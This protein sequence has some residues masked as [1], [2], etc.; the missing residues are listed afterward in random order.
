MILYKI[1]QKF[2]EACLQKNSIA[3]PILPKD[4]QS[5][6][7]MASKGLELSAGQS[8]T[9][10]ETHFSQLISSDIHT[11]FDS[12]NYPHEL[13]EIACGLAAI[14][15]RIEGAIPPQLSRVTGY[16]D[17][18]RLRWTPDAHMFEYSAGYTRPECPTCLEMSNN[19]D[20]AAILILKH[21]TCDGGEVVLYEGDNSDHRE[22][23]RYARHPVHD[24]VIYFSTNLFY[25]VTS[26]TKGTLT[27]LFQTLSISADVPPKTEHYTYGSKSSGKSHWCGIQKTRALYHVARYSQHPPQHPFLVAVGLGD[28]VVVEKNCP[29]TI[30]KHYD[31][32]VEGPAIIHVHFGMSFIDGKVVP[33]CSSRDV[34][35]T[36]PKGHSSQVEIIA[37]ANGDLEAAIS[38][39][40]E[41]E[42]G[43]KD[44]KSVSESICEYRS[45]V[46]RSFLSRSNDRKYLLCLQL[47]IENA[48]ATFPRGNIVI[49]H[50]ERAHTLEKVKE[51]RKKSFLKWY[52]HKFKA[53]QPDHDHST[54]D[55]RGSCNSVQ[56]IPE[57]AEILSLDYGVRYHQLKGR[58]GAFSP[59]DQKVVDQ[60]R[61]FGY[62]Y[63][64]V[65]LKDGPVEVVPG[66][67]TVL[68]DIHVY[69]ND[70]DSDC[71]S[72]RMYE[73]DFET[74]AYF[75]AY[76]Q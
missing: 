26:V 50:T 32:T 64:V 68:N 62:R 53:R 19:Y 58:K 12:K 55:W 36:I 31:E 25:F 17:F 49:D 67:N 14:P 45:R 39:P 76:W 56:T 69:V 42:L 70:C 6:L 28:C 54:M 47:G 7:K 16:D 4:N 33:T 35:I 15:R 65:F 63:R 5:Q 75:I 3:G 60:I 71:G 59:D 48:L 46:C 20:V 22:V 8:R 41:G 10:E 21:G 66:P 9:A 61:A 43:Q 40:T 51:S 30:H 74:S 24:R 38:K 52:D 11:L 29:D 13:E 57:H 1:P 44:E 34:V 2:P 37:D 27:T 72:H 73:C 18:H 23:A